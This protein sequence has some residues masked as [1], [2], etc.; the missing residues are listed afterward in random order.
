MPKSDRIEVDLS[1]P[2]KLSKFGKFVMQSD[3]FVLDLSPGHFQEWADGCAKA[4]ED[5]IGRI[6]GPPKPSTIERRGPGR[7]FNVTGYLA[8]GITGRV[9]RA[10]FE[11]AGPIG[12]LA[13][14]YVTKKLIRRVAVLR[15]LKRLFEHARKGQLE[16]LKKMM[17]VRK[18]VKKAA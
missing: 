6:S 15:R 9:F 14:D 2:P 4:I 17:Y 11:I 8:N 3:T 16:S 5:S 18:R 12:R 7:L 10:G 13:N 1:A